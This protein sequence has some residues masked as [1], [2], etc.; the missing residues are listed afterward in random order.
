MP[1]VK[2]GCGLHHLPFTR[3]KDTKFNQYVYV[4]NVKIYIFPLIRLDFIIIKYI[5]VPVFNG[6]ARFSKIDFM[7]LVASC[8]NLFYWTGIKTAFKMELSIFGWSN[9]Y[10]H[11]SHINKKRWKVSLRDAGQ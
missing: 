6:F 1:T 9:E 3:G 11:R 10:M 5:F 2:A 4:Y 7:R 8:T